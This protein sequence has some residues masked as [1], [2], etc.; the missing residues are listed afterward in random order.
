MLTILDGWGIAPDSKGNAVSQANTPN[1][2]EY[3]KTY[4]STY[5][6]ASGESVGLPRGEDGNSETGHLNLGAGRIVY[7][8][9]ARIN[10][11]IADGSFF[12]NKAFL[13]A[14]E[15]A[16][17]N[18]SNLH[19]MG[20]VGSG[21]VH[22][23]LEHLFALLHLCSRQN[24]K[25]VFVHTFTDGRDSPPNQA[26][27]YL[28][29][30]EE[31]MS[32]EGV[33]KIASVMGRYYSMDRD[34]R[35]DRTAK[36]YKALTQAEGFKAKSAQEA[37]EMAYERGETDEFI[38]PTVILTNEG[39]PTGLINNN[40]AVIFYNYRIDR[41]RQLTR[42][43][44]LENLDQDWGYDPYG[45][46][47]QKTS[48]K[49]QSFNRGELLKN[50][51]FVTTTLYENILEDK[52]VV[53][54]ERN[55]I[56]MPLGKVLSLHGISQLRVAE[57]EK[58]R[59]VTYYFNG[60]SAE[61]FENQDNIIFPSPDVATYDLKPQMSSFE[62]T[63]ALINKV[64]NY[65]FAV[66]NYAAPDMVAH[67]G[68]IQAAIKAAEAVDQ[69]IG[70]LHKKVVNEL[71]GY[72]I[73]TADHGNIEEMISKT[74]EADTEHSTN[75][76]PFIVASQSLKNKKINMPKGILADVAPTILELFGITPPDYMTGRNLLENNNKAPNNF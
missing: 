70:R 76:V 21:G 22:S 15:H 3:L 48:T 45:E 14:I 19:L 16:K 74:G 25:R 72:L 34:L 63:E 39:K 71:D 49:I 6:G 51:Y 31:V 57:S 56:K 54:F 8:Y 37:V 32:K 2:D 44:L 40:D 12:E 24:F 38:S 20:L 41:P 65:E 4:P 1:F 9:L 11:S 55:V 26:K 67:S 58:E 46:K 62:I 18:N 69:C 30:I 10:M 23:N 52:T 75:P 61:S 36:A 64:S 68:N 28:S 66:I 27:A 7:Q 35:W 17:Q 43:F 73:I 50:L 60:G 59:F 5:L 33:G 13:G 42:A 29:E 47:Y 53:A